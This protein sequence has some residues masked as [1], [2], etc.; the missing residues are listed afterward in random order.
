MAYEA[1]PATAGRQV[2]GIIGVKAG[3]VLGEMSVSASTTLVGL[4]AP[5]G[6]INSLPASSR[7]L[8]TELLGA[9]AVSS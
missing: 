5:R 9:P 8:S 3:K 1:L 6:V 2:K 4:E 7:Y